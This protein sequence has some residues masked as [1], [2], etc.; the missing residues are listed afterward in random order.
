[1]QCVA[2]GKSKGLECWSSSHRGT[3]YVMG[4][5]LLYVRFTHS[6]RHIATYSKGTTNRTYADYNQIN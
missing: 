2:S 5:G 6:Q 3:L 1:M 4:W